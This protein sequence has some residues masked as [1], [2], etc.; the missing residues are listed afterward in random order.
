MNILFILS[1]KPV[2]TKGGTERATISVASLLSRLGGH[3]CFAAY[4][5]GEDTPVDGCFE[6]SLDLRGARFRDAATMVAS[7]CCEQGIEVIINQGSLAFQR[8]LRELVPQSISLVFCHHYRPGWE[9]S[10]GRFG[11]QLMIL[12]NSADSVTRAKA[13]V[14]MVLYP[15]YRQWNLAKLRHR[16]REAYESS[17]AVVLLS[18]RF[19][20]GFLEFGRVKN[21]VGDRFRFIPN[22]L[23]FRPAPHVDL[24]SKERIVLIVA[25]FDEKQKRISLALDIWSAVKR[26]P[27][28]EGWKLRI[29]GHGPKDGF[30]RRKVERE[31]IPGVTFLGR[32]DPRVEYEQASIFMMTSVSEGWGLTL[33]EAQ[34]FGV[35]PVAFNTYESL[36]EIVCDGENG[37]VVSE[38]DIDAYVRRMLELMRDSELRERLSRGAM[39]STA[40]FS[41]EHIAREWERVLEEITVCQ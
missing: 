2:A 30:Y 20:E 38:G 1:Y 14:K 3:R 34:Q 31:G 7:Y 27:Q 23:T 4:F 8:P 11:T 41:D 35:V 13:A 29:V 39:A 37:F 25:R 28:A 16:Y 24:D 26:C 17:G 36:R 22:P 10:F 5:T 15:A 9:E 6:G 40:R 21:E 32:M 33:I 19:A 18:E 12:R